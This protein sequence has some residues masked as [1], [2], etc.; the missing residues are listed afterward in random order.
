MLTGSVDCTKGE[1]GLFLKAAFERQGRDGKASWWALSLA[2]RNSSDLINCKLVSKDMLICEKVQFF[3]KSSP[4]WDKVN[5]PTSWLR[6]TLHQVAPPF[7]GQRKATWEYVA[8]SIPQIRKFWCHKSWLNCW[9]AST[10]WLILTSCNQEK[11]QFD[12]PSSFPQH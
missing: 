3:L 2:S 6:I 12:Y 9:F 10:A 5:D 7:C 1:E 11:M 4:P 8:G